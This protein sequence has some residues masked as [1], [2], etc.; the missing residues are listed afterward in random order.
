[1]VNSIDQM[2]MT[3]AQRLGVLGPLK[4]EKWSIHQEWS[5]A[6]QE[7]DL[8]YYGLRVPRLEV[9]RSL[10]YQKTAGTSIQVSS[11]FYQCTLVH[12]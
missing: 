3:A 8:S 7:A 10:P 5:S 1:M 6:V 11:R 12:W 9:N 4:Q 2:R